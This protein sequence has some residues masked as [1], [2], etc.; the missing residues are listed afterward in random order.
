MA[1]TRKGL[2]AESLELV[3][4]AFDYERDVGNAAAANGD[5][6]GLAGLDFGA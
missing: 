2:E 1:G 6:D 4:E 3:H 5:G